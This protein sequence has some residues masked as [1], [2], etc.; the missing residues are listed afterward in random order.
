MPSH[1]LVEGRR[2][3]AAMN[4]GGP[5]VGA[6]DRADDL[7][8]RA[9]LGAAAPRARL[10]RAGGSSE[11]KQPR[12][13]R[14]QQPTGNVERRKKPLQ[15]QSRIAADQRRRHELLADDHK[16]HESEQEQ[17]NGRKTIV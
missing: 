12:S 3:G 10:T 15:G 1:T 5:A 7:E 2:A 16:D 13:E 17:R 8:R 4:R 6:L 9:E 11:P 14:P